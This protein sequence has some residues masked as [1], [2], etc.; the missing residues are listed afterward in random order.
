MSLFNVMDIASTGMS[1]QSVRLN[2]TASNVANANS[3]SSS[4]DQTYK[5]RHPVFAAELQRA[6]QDQNAG[7]GV[8]V[9][10]VVESQAPLQIEYSPGHP[11][12][13]ENG[14]I[15]KPNVNIVEEM[16]DM[17]SASK[18]Y[19]TNVQV[20]DTTKRLFRNVL[21]LGQGS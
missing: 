21:R 7:T 8:Q 17:M 15:Y 1:A 6:S 10:G 3:V 9:L 12:A 18:A 20:A 13:D 4:Y 14:Y 19:E 2:T 16:A 5:A 11:M